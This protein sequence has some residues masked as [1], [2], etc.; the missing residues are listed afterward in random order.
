MISDD[1]KSL[2]LNCAYDLRMWANSAEHF[3]GGIHVL[4][5]THEVC[6][7]MM[8]VI[9][10]SMFWWPGEDAT[11]LTEIVNYPR[12]KCASMFFCAGKMK[13]IEEWMKPGGTLDQWAGDQECD[14]VQF[15]AV[16]KGWFRAVDGLIETGRI[17]HRSL[18]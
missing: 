3:A 4:R 15:I 8:G 7:L 9:T 14:R 18:Q 1:P 12:I 2:D 11:C 10:G 17:G 5:G 13:E 16:R 6:D